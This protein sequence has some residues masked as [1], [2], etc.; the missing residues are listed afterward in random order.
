MA[1]TIRAL[2]FFLQLQEVGGAFQGVLQE[3]AF[4]AGADHAHG[5]LAE[6][7]RMAGQGLVE[8]RALGHLVAHV[9]E[10]LGQRWRACLL[11]EDPERRQAA[12]RRSAAGRPIG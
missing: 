1:P 12:A 5:Q 4:G 3:R 6:D 8:R 9:G 2:Q 10:H 11:G 7:V